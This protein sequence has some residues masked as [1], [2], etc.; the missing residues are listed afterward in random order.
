MIKKNTL[1]FILVYLS[2][3]AMAQ[4]IIRVEE[5]IATALQNNYDIRLSKNDSMVAALDY[6][7]R[8]AA[9]QPRLS[10]N[11]GF[12]L[13]NN[14]QKQKFADGT[15]RERKGIR[16][17]N[18]TG[19]LQLN[20]VVFDGMKMFVTRDKLGELVRLSTLSIRNQAVQ[21][22]AEVISVYYM[23]VRQ[24]QQLKATAELLQISEE[25]LKLAQFRLQNGSGTRPD[26][27]QSQVDRNAQ[28]SAQL[29]QQLVLDQQKENLLRLMNVAAGQ[30]F[31]VT[32]SVPVNMD[33]SFAEIS[34]KA[35]T[36]NPGLLS[37]KKNIEIAQ[38]TLKERRAERLPVVSFNSAYNYGKLNNKAVVNPFSP[39]Y[40][41]NNGFNFGLTAT[42]PILDNQQNKRLTR[43]AQL[44]I[45]FRRLAYESEKA[46]VSLAVL[47]AYK[48]Y[49]AQIAILK[50]EEENIVIAREN[51]RIVQETYKLGA[52]T[53][54][55][56]RE[57]QRS[58][59]EAQNR[60]IGV[61][62]AAKLA[63][64]ELQRLKGGW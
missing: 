35:E 58:L 16:S 12:V 23:A 56:F 46:T 41:R 22:A 29:S 7:F 1:L 26:V 3:G 37:L 42:I 24:K 48:N 38:F 20:W 47:N 30:E 62:Y 8:N 57:A 36:E 5:A 19:S 52:T 45:E 40:S 15:N 43:Q 33:L 13:N 32:D 51:L 50:L 44:D 34:S 17:D 61:R 10:A 63:E 39:L 64:T 31:D 28:R 25:R 59:E 49:R 54:I 21:S 55:Q 9:F 6:S 11:A 53:F 60:L 4:R 2:S 18:L 14:D 27:L